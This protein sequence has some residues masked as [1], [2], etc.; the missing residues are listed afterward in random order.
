MQFIRRSAA[1]PLDL[2]LQSEN[3]LRVSGTGGIRLFARQAG[4]ILDDA[5][6]V[7]TSPG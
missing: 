1:S 2:P 4:R 6:R 3:A 5:L 7:G